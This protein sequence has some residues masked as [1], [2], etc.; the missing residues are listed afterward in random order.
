MAAVCLSGRVVAPF[1][2]ASVV[3]LR[4]L[5]EE[6]VKEQLEAAKPEPIIEEVV[7]AWGCPHPPL[8]LLWVLFSFP[9]ALFTHPSFS[10][11]LYSLSTS[12]FPL[13]PL[14]PPPFSPLFLPLSPVFYFPWG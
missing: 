5:V 3:V 13:S 10:S 12:L 14:L 7:S 9:P 2:P 11:H 4:P 6:K 8:L 1:R